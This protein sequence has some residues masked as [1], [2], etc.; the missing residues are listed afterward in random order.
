LR[1][2]NAAALFWRMMS[3]ELIK[4]MRQRV[5]KCRW[6]ASM[7]NDPE[8]RKALLQMAAEGEADIKKLEAEEAARGKD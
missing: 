7:I 4:N 6:L 1:N 5:A 3:K 8:G 2:D